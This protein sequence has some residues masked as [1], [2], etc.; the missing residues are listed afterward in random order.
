MV[1]LMRRLILLTAVLLM[2]GCTSLIFQPMETLVRTPAAVGLDYRELYFRADDGTLLHAWFLPTEGEARGTV[3][4]LHGNAENISTHLGS[5]W[6]LP[7]AGYQVLLY[8]YR[9]YGHS[10]GKPSLEGMLLDFEAALHKTRQLPEVQGRPLAVFG[11]SLGGAVAVS[12]VARSAQRARIQALIIEGAFSDYR[13][14]A[15][16]KLSDFWLTWPFQWPLSLTIDNS[17]RP[18]D[19]IGHISPIPLL[20]MHGTVDTIIPRHHA[21]ALFAA[22]GEPKQYWEVDGAPHIG[23]LTTPEMRQRFVDYLDTTLQPRD[24][25]A[26]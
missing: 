6:W 14:I 1:F 9:G 19:D 21:A 25:S 12:A 23:A 20:V 24:A 4:F 18:L 3:L 26:P 5:V 16:E 17:Y 22:A 15:R 7:A 10:E 11:Q 2:Q 8:D 13:K